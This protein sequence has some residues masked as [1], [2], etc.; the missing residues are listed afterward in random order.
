M[1][2]DRPAP[3]SRPDVDGSL[4]AHASRVDVR[5][6]KGNRLDRSESLTWG[7]GRRA[8]R[9]EAG[10]MCSRVG[11]RQSG[12][13]Q[14]S[15][16][17]RNNLQTPARLRLYVWS[18]ISRSRWT[19]LGI[20]FHGAERDQAGVKTPDQPPHLTGAAMSVSR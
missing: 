17:R 11:G 10:A 15:C 18:R 3:R 4:L 12:L 5:P 7:P 16:R 9:A 13:A 20:R 19:Y 6:S 2:G 1:P 8:R 14:G